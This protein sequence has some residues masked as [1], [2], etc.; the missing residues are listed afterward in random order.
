[1]IS[2]IYHSE[3]QFVRADGFNSSF[4]FW[5]FKQ[6]NMIKTNNFYVDLYLLSFPILIIF[7]Y[8]FLFSIMIYMFFQR[9]KVL[10][11]ILTFTMPFCPL[12]T[13]INPFSAFS[14]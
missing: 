3:H 10:R 13:R 8:S 12:V 6:A 2:V 1:M 9:L 4:V 5:P 7:L 14:S 11:N